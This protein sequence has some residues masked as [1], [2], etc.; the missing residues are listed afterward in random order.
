V[1]VSFTAAGFIA[2]GISVLMHMNNPS[3]GPIPSKITFFLVGTWALAFVWLLFAFPHFGYSHQRG[4][5]RCSD[6]NPVAA[7]TYAQ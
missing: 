1:Y 2:M 5:H 7:P 4:F 3:L 6:P